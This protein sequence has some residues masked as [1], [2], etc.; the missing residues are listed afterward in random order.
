MACIRCSYF[1][2]I[3]DQCRYLPTMSVTQTDD[4]WVPTV[5]LATRR[6]QRHSRCLVTA[7]ITAAFLALPSNG[8]TWLTPHMR[9]HQICR[10]LFPVLR[11]SI[12]PLFSIST[13]RPKTLS[14]QKRQLYRNMTWNVN[15]VIFLS[16]HTIII[17][18]KQP[19]LWLAFLYE[20]VHLVAARRYKPEGRRFDSRWCHWNFSLT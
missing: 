4:V 17:F 12:S 11:Y 10:L 16:R 19:Y 8:V 15:K 1:E 13:P 14:R 2:W 20:V 5:L 7:A 9:A 18:C 3:Y 6:I